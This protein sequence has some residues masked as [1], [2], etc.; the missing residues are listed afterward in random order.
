MDDKEL[1]GLIEVDL[2]MTTR[3]L[4]TRL[5]CANSTVYSHFLAM[6]KVIM[7]SSRVPHAL[8]QV[9]RDRPYLHVFADAFVQLQLGEVMLRHHR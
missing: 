3:S 8:S 1:H 2:R 4:A 9:H 5:G 7:L 6:G